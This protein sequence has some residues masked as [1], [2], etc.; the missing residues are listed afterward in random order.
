MSLNVYNTL[1]NQKEEFRPLE[2]NKVRMYVCGPTVYDKCHIGHARCYVAFDVIRRYLEYCGHDVTFVENF[3][4]VDDKIIKKS[5][6][7]G[8]D[9][10][11]IAERNIKDY[12]RDMD[13]L[14]VQRADLYPRATKHVA[15]MIA[16]IERLLEKGYAYV[17]DGDVYFSVEK[18]AD[19]G[20]LS[21][22]NIEQM[23][24]GARIAVDE[25]KRDPLDFALWK[26]AKEGEPSWESPWGEGRPGWHI[27]CST[28]TLKHLGE[29]LDIHGGGQDLIF[30]H[31]EN[32][33]AQSEAYSGKQF[34]RYWLHNGFV[35]IRE[36]KMSKSLGNIV[37]VGDL[38]QQYSPET[39][40]YFLVA[41]HYRKPIDFD[42]AVLEESRK[43][44]TRL[45]NTVDLVK[46]ALQGGPTGESFSVKEYRERFQEAMDDDFNTPGA[47]SVLFELVR[48]TN[49]RIEE[50]NIDRASLEDVLDTFRV[51]AGDVLGLFFEVKTE[52]VSEELLEILIA[53]REM[54]RQKK[55]WDVSDT[56]RDRLREIGI[57]LE[58]TP[59]GTRWK[60]V[61]DQ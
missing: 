2:K 40:R 11:E 22:V 1:T 51:L 19:Y 36:E 9:P 50:K 31:H 39:L 3:T 26:K 42:E 53:V 6:E 7:T 56:I 28:M 48:D 12:F 46:G 41:S 20:K 55:L 27:E 49:R 25:K 23:K 30:P 52:E 14:N 60:L 5:N 16:F 13:A 37:A 43:A 44:V 18:V 17:A 59:E 15:D 24:A 32:E 8:E 47:L 33:I 29:T 10:F 45:L 4:D 34:V 57:V 58:D 38:L 61:R 54:V 35:T 21:G